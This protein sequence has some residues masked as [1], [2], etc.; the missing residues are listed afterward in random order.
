MV[1]AAKL[2]KVKELKP[3]RRATLH[4]DN[5]PHERFK[6]SALSYFGTIDFCSHTYI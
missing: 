5:D 1:P 3:L 2:A 6:I 4:V